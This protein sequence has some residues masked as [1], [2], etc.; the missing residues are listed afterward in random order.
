MPLSR[1]TAAVGFVGIL[2]TL[3]ALGRR[4]ST[5]APK[6]MQVDWEAILGPTPAEFITVVGPW[7]RASLV[8]VNI[9]K[10][11]PITKMAPTVRSALEA[12][13]AAETITPSDDVLKMLDP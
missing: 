10:V 5:Q 2:G 1:G 4:I 13:A 3:L 7:I 9:D 8:P 12:I 6:G 11:L